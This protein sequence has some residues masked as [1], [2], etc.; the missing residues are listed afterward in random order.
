LFQVLSVGKDT[1]EVSATSGFLNETRRPSC[2]SNNRTFRI[3][4]F[5]DSKGNTS[6]DSLKET[7]SSLTSL[8][9]GKLRQGHVPIKSTGYVTSRG[10]LR[11]PLRDSSSADSAASST[12]STSGCVVVVQTQTGNS[13]PPTSDDIISCFTVMLDCESVA[14][15]TLMTSSICADVDQQP[16]T[17]LPCQ[18][19]DVPGLSRDQEG[20]PRRRRSV[21]IGQTSVAFCK[22]FDEGDDESHN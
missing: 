9:S 5:V 1:P 3:Q 2:I 15:Q 21:S 20:G 10:V 13:P 17:A 14:R 19:L 18:S 8:Q 7:Y 16:L 12:N 4:S 11:S 22:S 6:S